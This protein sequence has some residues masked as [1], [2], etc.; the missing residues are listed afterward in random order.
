MARPR[1]WNNGCVV[2]LDHLRNLACLLSTGIAM[3]GYSRFSRWFEGIF[4]AT[5][6]VIGASLIWAD[7]RVSRNKTKVESC[8]FV[9]AVSA[10][11]AFNWMNRICKKYD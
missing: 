6:G 1:I 5:F 9:A 2:G 3:R 11:Q 10:F 4:A 8:E 7:V